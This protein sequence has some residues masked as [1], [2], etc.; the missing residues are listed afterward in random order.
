LVAKPAIETLLQPPHIHVV[1]AAKVLQE[2]ESLRH[3][4]GANDPDKHARIEI[5]QLDAESD[6][7][8]V[9]ELVKEANIVIR[10][11]EPPRKKKTSILCCF[12][13]LDSMDIV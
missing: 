9:S 5:V 7:A 10:C 12:L 11:D 2:A 13:L 3:R 4:I 1:I 6:R 8:G